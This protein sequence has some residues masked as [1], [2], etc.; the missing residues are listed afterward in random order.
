[1]GRAVGGQPFNSI[2]QV[3]FWRSA[4]ERGIQKTL[5]SSPCCS[6]ILGDNG[7]LY[8]VECHVSPRFRIA[9]TS[10]LRSHSA[11]RRSDGIVRTDRSLTLVT[12]FLQQRDAVAVPD[13]VASI[14]KR[15]SV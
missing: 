6:H 11:D 10:D 8:V 9:N 13:P 12:R 1:M 5:Q 2:A 7:P 15:C 3:T 14:W 4:A